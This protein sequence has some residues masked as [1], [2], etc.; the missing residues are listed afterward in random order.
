MD[1]GGS[2][3]V[4]PPATDSADSVR[5]YAYTRHFLNLAMFY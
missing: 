4:T 2:G 5:V 1:F 3:V